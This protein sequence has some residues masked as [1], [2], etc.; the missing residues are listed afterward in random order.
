MKDLSLPPDHKLRTIIEQTSSTPV[1]AEIDAIANAVRARHEASVQAIL[2]YG[3]C[4]RGEHVQ[5]TL[6]DL[7][8]LVENYK[9]THKN[10]LSGLSNKLLP[11]N[12]YYQECSYDGQIIRCKYALLTLDQFH[13]KVSPETSNP[14]FWARFC[15]PTALIYARDDTTRN[16]VVGALMQAVCTTFAEAKSLIPAST[17][18]QELW[19]EILSNTYRT[20]LRPEKS[21]RAALIVT[22]NLTY[23]EALYD[24][25]VMLPNSDVKNTNWSQRRIIGK[26]L[27]IARLIKAAFTFDGGADYLAWKISRHSGEEINLTAWQ[28]R[29]PILAAPKLFWQL[30][31]KGAV[32]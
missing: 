17:S 12:V 31:A 20:E 2:G 25:L 14:Y 5:D 9:T 13:K 16:K 15:Q 28:R 7:Y 21:N 22:T 29:H 1:I 4:L 8:V 18:P 30:Y 24:A 23:F 10:H 32:R 19:S 11:P 6:V 27:T 3:S 26:L